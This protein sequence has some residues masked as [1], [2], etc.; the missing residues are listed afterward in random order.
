M[1]AMARA[2]MCLAEQQAATNIVASLLALEVADDSADIRMYI[3]SGG[4]SWNRFCCR[5]HMPHE[6]YDQNISTGIAIVL[7]FSLLCG[8]L[9]SRT[10]HVTLPPSCAPVTCRMGKL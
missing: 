1:D 3:N 6:S 9:A 2:D 10:P 7:P 4:T 5:F 8:D